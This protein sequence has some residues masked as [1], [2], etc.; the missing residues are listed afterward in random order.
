MRRILFP[1]FFVLVS[2]LT[3]QCQKELRFPDNTGN[4]TVGPSPIKATLQG[5]ILDENGQPAAGVTVRAGGTTVITDSRGYFRMV[6]VSLDKNASLVTAEK[7]GYFKAYRTFPATNGANHVVIKLIKRTLTGT[8]NATA[9]GE[10]ILSNGAKVALPANGVV[11]AAG[12][13]SYTGTVNVYAAYI[14]P[15]SNDIGQTVP[16]S[17]M[18]DNKEGERVSLQSYG[19]LAVELESSAGEKLQIAAGKTA[20]ITSPIPASVLAAAPASIPLWYVDE[21]TGLWKEEGSAVKNGSNY[22][23][24]VKH[25]TFWNCDAGFPAV[26]LTMKMVDAHNVPMP[27]VTVRLTRNVSGAS[28][29]VSYGFSDSLGNIS[30]LVPAGET[31]LLEVLNNCNTP[32]Y[33][34]NIGPFTQATNLGSISS[35]STWQVTIS[36]TIV[37]CSGVPVING[38]AIIDYEDW[39]RY[40]STGSNGF[41]QFTIVRCTTGPGSCAITAVDNTA[42]QQS[43]SSFT[44]AGNT[45]NTGNLVACG[46]SAAQFINYTLD[47]VNYSI[48][49]AEAPDYIY[50]FSLLSGASSYTNSLL[51]SKNSLNKNINLSFISTAQVVGVYPL[52]NISTQNYQSINV[53]TPSTVT[54][55]N[56]P[57]ATGAFFEG[58]FNGSFRDSLNLTVVHTISGDFKIRRY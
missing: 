49:S 3:I 42:L 8:I 26:M 4:G 21:Q 15:T 14:D 36:G 56:F 45:L 32:V 29:P 41:F 37:D 16:G 18:G 50:G 19:M 55:T 11:K 53:L 51:G 1:L 7:N 13:S 47:G 5:R 9:G 20:T 48:T 22:V 6:K 43:T 57:G 25:F 35:S 30:G 54:V 33:S 12:N 28:W 39:P 31:L 23:G 2:M 44:I 58:S 24:E 10:V 17:F 34:Q 27:Y 52:S 40:V 46:V 38:V